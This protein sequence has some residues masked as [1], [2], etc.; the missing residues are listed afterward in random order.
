MTKDS[1][2]DDNARAGGTV[3][4]LAARAAIAACEARGIDTEPVLKAGRLSR[5][6]LAS[7]EYRLPYVNVLRLWEAAGNAANDP[8]FGVRVAEALPV[9]AY[10]VLDYL[11]AAAATIGEAIARFAEYVRLLHDHCDARLI[12]EPREARIVIRRVS[13]PAPQ[14]DDFSIALFLVRSR[15]AA[16]VPWTPSG[17][18]VQHAASGD[19]AALSRLARCPIAFG[20][21]HTE[22]RFERSILQLPQAHA[23][24]RLLDILTRYA[25]SLLRALPSRGDLVAAV[26]SSIARQMGRGLP[27]LSST[28]A[29]VR[30]PER[31]LQRR[32]AATGVSHAV[33]IDEVRRGLA[34]KYVGDAALSLGE[35]A[36]LLHFSEPTSFCRAFKRWTAEGPS[37][38]R[39][40][41]FER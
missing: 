40:R 1:A 15:A 27:T 35:I 26:S 20:A 8:A 6:A 14:Y 32:L 28:A 24:S 17:I 31:T 30:L 9:G 18:A 2:S 29:E 4:V 5:E 33:L 38:Y 39:R 16:G 12:V 11:C 19:A 36:Y 13:V 25:D 23:D 37:Q 21:P 3:S 7:I 41:L 34:L 22:V 10:D